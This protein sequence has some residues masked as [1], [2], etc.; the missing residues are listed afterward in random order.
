[1]SVYDKVSLCVT[2][3]VNI[4]CHEKKFYGW[5]RERKLT[6]F[7]GIYFYRRFCCIRTSG[8]SVEMVTIW[9]TIL[10]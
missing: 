3:F 2:I 9:A 1:M 8:L 5:S 7:N 4:I 6:D 10:Y